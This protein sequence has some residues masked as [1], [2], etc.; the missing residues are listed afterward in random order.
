MLFE[1][2]SKLIISTNPGISFSETAVHRLHNEKN[3]KNTDKP[4]ELSE[5]VGSS[6]LPQLVPAIWQSAH[7]VK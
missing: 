2:T 1:W 3:E 4:L 7:R 6:G 5:N